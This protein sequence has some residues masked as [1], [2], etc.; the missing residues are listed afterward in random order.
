MGYY[1]KSN[2]AN[3]ALIAVNELSS[4]VSEVTFDGVF[5][6]NTNHYK[7]VCVDMTSSDANTSIR[8]IRRNDGSDVTT[9]LDYE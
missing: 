9:T 3:P 7:L 2:A 4:A 5:T 1:G 6:G 8:V